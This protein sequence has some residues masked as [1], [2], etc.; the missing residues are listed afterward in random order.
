MVARAVSVPAEQFDSLEQ[1]RQAATFG[2]WVFLVTEVMLFGGMFAAYAYCRFLYP[3]GFAE[4]SR[5]MELALGGTNTAV[6]I[7][8]SLT[9]ALAVH[10]A[11][12]GERKAFKRYLGLTIVLGLVFLAVKGLEYWHHAAD[13]L[14]PG[15]AFVFEGPLRSQVELFFFFYFVMTGIHALHLTIAVCLVAW[16]L[17]LAR[18]GHFTPE[19]HNPVEV[20]GLYWHFVDI[21]WLFLLPLLYLVGHA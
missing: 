13:H 19:A 20:V 1:Q 7:V 15:A 16:L 4:G 17:A 12:N 8:S 3:A 14:V 9:I 2:M 6:L 18:R 5:H 11:Q 21:V 10:A